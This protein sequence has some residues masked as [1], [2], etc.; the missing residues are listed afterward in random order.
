MQHTLPPA[1]LVR[2]VYGEC[3][4]AE[5]E[6]IRQRLDQDPGLREAYETLKAGADALGTLRLAPRP[7][8]VA[9]LLRYSRSTAPLETTR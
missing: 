7:G 5:S 3:S 9:D 1:F 2:Y 4:P 8:T 6:T